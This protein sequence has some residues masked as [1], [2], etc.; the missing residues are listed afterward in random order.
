MFVLIVISPLLICIYFV[1]L[2]DIGSPL[3]IQERVGINKR[4]FK[5][6]KFR[7]MTLETP[8]IATHL[9]ENTSISHISNFLRKRKLD[10]LPQFWNVLKGDMSI[11]GPRPGLYNQ[12]ELIKKRDSKNIFKVRP[13]ITGLAQINKVDMSTPSLLAYLD[14]KM[15]EDLTLSSYMKYLIITIRNLL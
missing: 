14:N 5:L 1:V 7:T 12:E 9:L 8:S 4:P 6:I 10:E 3:F 11:V 15:I 13:G 2:F